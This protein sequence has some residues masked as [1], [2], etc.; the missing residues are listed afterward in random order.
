METKLLGV[1][2]LLGSL[3]VYYTRDSNIDQ[4]IKT[5]LRLP[6]KTNTKTKKFNRNLNILIAIFLLL[7]GIVLLFI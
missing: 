3:F 4:K 5:L 6:D 2:S 1:I 7:C